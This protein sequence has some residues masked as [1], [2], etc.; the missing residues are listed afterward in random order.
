[1]RL[2]YG[3]FTALVW[4]VGCG[5]STAGT[6]GTGATGGSGGTGLAGGSGGTAGSGGLG[7]SGGVGATG[8]T[9]STGGTS[10][11]G[12]TGTGGGPSQG[13]PPPPD[14]N[15]PPAQDP[16]AVTF[17]VQK[18][19]LGDIGLNGAPSLNAWMSIGLNVDGL[20][21]NKSSTNHCQP[22][23][24][25][26]KSSVFT[27][28][29]SGIDNSFGRNLIPIISSLTANP[30]DSLNQAIASGESTWLL[31]FD[32]LGSSPSQNGVKAALYVSSPFGGVPTWSGS[33]AWPVAF[34]SVV[35]G[36]LG[37]PVVSYPASYVVGGQWV[38]APAS[39]GALA[40]SMPIQGFGLDFKVR[41]ARLVVNVS[42]TGPAAKAKGVLSGVIDT[43]EYVQALKQVAGSFDPTLCDG[44]TF[45][46]IAQQIRAASDIMSDGTNGDP[47]Q[48]CNGI[49]IGVG[50]EATVAALGAVSSPVPPPPNPCK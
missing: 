21:S 9:S 8:G 1:M 34:E 25:A 23:V 6:A 39:S 46:S 35:G 36:A 7:A 42:G 12:G 14:P 10:G 2:R 37:Q 17:A 13:Q 22:Q 38:G 3:V 47:T 30:S 43:E 50:L 26:T 45:D 19:F 33:D 16:K 5:G 31:H 24:G 27:D 44:P 29:D 11:A 4:V 18:F 28:G 40:W 49:S 15:A 41:H 48:V 32:N 20:V